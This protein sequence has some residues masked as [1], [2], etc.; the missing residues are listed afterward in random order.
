MYKRAPNDIII[1]GIEKVLLTV[2]RNRGFQVNLIN[3]DKEFKEVENKV[4]AHVEICA[5]GQEIPYIKLGI[6]F[7]K[8]RTRC[9]WVP[10]LP[11]KKVSKV[12][13]DDDCLTMV[14]NTRISPASIVLGR[15]KIDGN[16]NLK[17]TFGRYYTV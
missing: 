1:N 2:F 8:D 16:K 14:I 12:M 11:F 4:T 5:A 9:Y 10:L 7:I 13:V 15:G 6:Q 17:A 3:A